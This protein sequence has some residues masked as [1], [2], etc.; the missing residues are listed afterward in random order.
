M[1]VRGLTP[2]DRFWQYVLKDTD[3]NGCWHW[4]GAASGPYGKLFICR[5][6]GKTVTEYAHRF[7]DALFH[8]PIPEGIEVDHCCNNTMCVNPAHFERVT[9]LENKRRQGQRQTRCIHGHAYTLANTYIDP[10]G[11]RRCRRC[12]RER[13]MAA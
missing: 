5:V 12:A 11:Q 2:E 1:T 4:G 3:P 10:S 6:D 7:S 8:G 13:R 9:P